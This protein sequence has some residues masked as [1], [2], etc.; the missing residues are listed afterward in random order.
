M[1]LPHEVAP[2]FKAWLDEHYPDRARKVMATI[3]D[4]RGGKD[5]DPRFFS[6]LRGQGV[7]AD[8]FRKRFEKA[9]RDHGLGRAK[10]NLNCS[11]FEPP[12]GPQLRLL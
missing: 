2:L 4:L 12:Q 11:L 9:C 6:R 3:R 5:N 8:L 7:W 1:R 10:F